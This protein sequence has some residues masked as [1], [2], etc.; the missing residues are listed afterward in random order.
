MLPID[1][2]LNPGQTVAGDLNV[3][4]LAGAGAGEVALHRNETWLHLGDALINLDDTGLAVLPAKYCLDE[5]Q[6]ADSL[7]QLKSLAFHS[8][9][10]AHGKPIC[11]DAQGRIRALLETLGAG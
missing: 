9:T 6:L 10:F 11:G 2:T 1:G 8:A 3:I 7:G 4:S 5:G